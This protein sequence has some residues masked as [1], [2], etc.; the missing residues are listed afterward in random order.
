MIHLFSVNG[1]VHFVPIRHVYE[2][3]KLFHA[4]HVLFVFL[5]LPF[6]DFIW[7]LMW[8]QKAAYLQFSLSGIYWP[9]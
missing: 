6:Y 7:S 8:Q 3:W 2:S 5:Y 9:P 4:Q 1:L